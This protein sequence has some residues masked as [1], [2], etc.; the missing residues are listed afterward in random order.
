MKSH[1]LLLGRVL[2]D[3]S[4]RC[5]TSTTLDYNTVKSRV[6]D[7]G[8]SFLTIALPNFGSDFERSLDQG[9]V[10]STFFQGF[11]R[12]GSLPAFLQ[13]LTSLVFN[14]CD[15]TLLNT[16]SYEA[17]RCVRQICYLFKALNHT[18]SDARVKAAY[19]KY[20]ECEKSVRQSDSAL[21]TE[22][23]FEFMSMADLLFQK[24]LFSKLDREV[25]LGLLIPKH[26]PG[27][28]ADRL[29][30]NAKF[31]NRL[32][33]ER[34]EELFPAGEFLYT[35]PRHYFNDVED[36]VG[37]IWLEPDTEIPSRVITVPKT[38]KTP[39]IIAIEPTHMQYVQQGLMEPIVE[40]I[41]RDD[42]LSSF[43]GFT[44][45]TVNRYLARKGSANGDLATLD[46]SEASDRVSN[47]H[48]QLLLG[49]N[50]F[51]AE[52][53]QACRSSMQM[54]LAMGFFPWPS[55]RL[56]VQLSLFLW[57]PWSS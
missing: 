41:E 52:G 56:W 39:R 31:D 24:R 9:A 21:E 8:L 38:L 30:A 27:A 44:D 2:Q 1:V 33:T 46:L 54:C 25:E 5:C 36:G 7:E 45:Q 23:K 35:S 22:R 55:S 10:D 17:I 34:L 20:V 42:F 3:S 47:L 51:L 26:G 53:V 14:P 50:P 29:K 13:G 18:C 48:V 16:P 6:K 40:G 57:K 43:I 4:I 19:D 32:W 15:G 49:R 12:K 28:T 37:P 11:R